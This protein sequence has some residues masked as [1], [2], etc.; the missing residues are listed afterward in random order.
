MLPITQLN[1]IPGAIRGGGGNF[2]VVTEF[3]LKLHEQRKTVFSGQ[4][5]Y[6]GV[7]APQVFEIVNKL[8][9]EKKSPKTAMG[10]F[11]AS[12]PPAHQVNRPSVSFCVN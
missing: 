2:G 11:M 10:V 4:L 5:I 3:V 12:P 7:M 8:W 6:P 1:I 9:A